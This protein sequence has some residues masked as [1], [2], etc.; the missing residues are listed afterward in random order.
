MTGRHLRACSIAATGPAR[1]RSRCTPGRASTASRDNPAATT[2]KIILRFHR[3]VGPRQMRR[4]MVARQSVSAAEVAVLRAQLCAAQSGAQGPYL[5][6][7]AWVARRAEAHAGSI[8]A[9]GTACAA[10][11]LVHALRHT[12]DPAR[13]PVVWVDAL[14]ARAASDPVALL[15]AKGAT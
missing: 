3:K 8:P 6:A 2:R 11:L 7:L 10:L 15:Q 1:Q 9:E 4:G 12:Y 13:D 14:I 5:S